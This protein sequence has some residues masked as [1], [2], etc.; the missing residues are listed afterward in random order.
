FGLG[1]AGMLAASLGM[2]AIIRWMLDTGET[3]P[4]Y[5]SRRA[6]AAGPAGFARALDAGE[7]P[8][9]QSARPRPSIR[10]DRLGDNVVVFD[11]T[12]A[13][14]KDRSAF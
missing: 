5:R 12:R 13:R 11:P 3:Y 8:Q 2:F 7:R 10:P 6:V 14:R 4:D 1:L 9:P